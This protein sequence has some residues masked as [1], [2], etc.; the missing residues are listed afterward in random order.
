MPELLVG[1]FIC[2]HFPPQ[3]CE[4]GI[5]TIHI[6]QRKSSGFPKVIQIIIDGVKIRIQLFNLGHNTASLQLL[7]RGMNERSH[8]FLDYLE[9]S[10][11]LH[12]WHIKMHGED[13]SQVS[14]LSIMF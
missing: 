13:L 2:F 7:E 4:M 12:L 5:V 8:A 9:T 11:K 14:A 1:A 6:L 10:W 3:L